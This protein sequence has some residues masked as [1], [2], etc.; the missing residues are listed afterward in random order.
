M[1]ID[2]AAPAKLRSLS[3]EVAKLRAIKSKSEQELM[4][5]AADISG[6]AHAKVC[7]CLPLFQVLTNDTFQAMCFAQ[8]DMSEHSI[9]AH[10]EYI[11]AVNGAQRP[12]YVPVVAS[13]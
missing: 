11:C 4:R 9:A 12:A 7:S 6:N 8:P 10:F 2:K 1:V 13:G 3:P 5:T